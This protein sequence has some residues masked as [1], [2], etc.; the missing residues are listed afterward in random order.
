MS[1]AWRGRRGWEEPVA[2]TSAAPPPERRVQGKMKWG[3]PGLGTAWGRK[4]GTKA[5]ER[6]RS[7]RDGLG[8]WGMGT[9]SFGTT[10]SAKAPR[11]AALARASRATAMSAGIARA[12]EARKAAGTLARPSQRP[13]KHERKALERLRKQFDP[14]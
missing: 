4:T 10:S 3:R 9:A 7:G 2:E 14:T 1:T 6:G 8:S 5:A 11:G 12:A 13:G